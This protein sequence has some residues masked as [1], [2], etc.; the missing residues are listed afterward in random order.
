MT[1]AEKISFAN[2]WRD[3]MRDLANKMMSKNLTSRDSASTNILQ[4]LSDVCDEEIEWLREKVCSEEVVVVASKNEEER[5]RTPVEQALHDARSSIAL[6]VLRA[7]AGNNST[8][9]KGCCI[10]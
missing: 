4:Y 6:R 3:F 10:S 2:E 7:F 9:E 1:E 5:N 8:N